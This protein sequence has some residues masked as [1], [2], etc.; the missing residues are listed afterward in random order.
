MSTSDAS[1]GQRVV[2]YGTT[3]LD[4]LAYLSLREDECR[5]CGIHWWKSARVVSR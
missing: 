3:E 2:I 5:L 1:H 4:E